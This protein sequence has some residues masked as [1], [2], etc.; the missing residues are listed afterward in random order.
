M[1]KGYV[2]IFYDWLDNTEDLSAEEKGNLIDAVIS[3]ASDCEYEHLLT[4][5][6]VKVAFKFM[7]GAV[8][9]SAEISAS[10]SKAASKDTTENKTEQNEANENKTEQT[11]TN[12]NDKDNNKDNNKEKDK[13]QKRF[14]PPSVEEVAAYCRERGNNVD[15]EAFVA[16]YDSKGWKV[17]NTP[18]R[19]WKSAIITW[20]KGRDRSTQQVVVHKKVLPA[21]DYKQRDYSDMEQELW[22][23][24]LKQARDMGID[25]DRMMSS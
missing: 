3:Y 25:V 17:G 19:N 24:Q 11:E 14:T 22:E 12:A 9:R 6:A 21:Q 13:K 18:M 10:R 15:A 16:F 2:P 5:D 1:A 4:T 8:D 23:R 20:E 7:R